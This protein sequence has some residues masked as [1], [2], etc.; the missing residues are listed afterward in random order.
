MGKQL[1]HTGNRVGPVNRAFRAANDFDFIDVVEREAGKI[2]RATRW[3]DRRAIDQNEAFPPQLARRPS[4]GFRRGRCPAGGPGRRRPLSVA[5][6]VRGRPAGRR[7]A[8]DRPPPGRCGRSSG[9]HG[10]AWWWRE[11]APAPGTERD[12]SA[13][14]VEELA[15]GF[16][17][18]S[19]RPIWPCWAA[20][21][22][23]RSAAVGGGPRDAGHCRLPSADHPGRRRGHPRR[24]R[25]AKCCGC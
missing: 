4:T 8:V 13:F 6:V 14:Q 24:A 3:I 22:G 21:D 11:P 12:G 9:R 1:D 25:A 19:T 20:A 18:F 17:I 5:G 2:Y 16:Q 15:G 7:R 10:S 23:Q